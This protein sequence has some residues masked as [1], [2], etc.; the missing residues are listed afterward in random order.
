MSLSPILGSGWIVAIHTFAAVAALFVGAVQLTRSKGTASHRKL[1]YV[2]IALMAVAAATSF[3]I[4]EIRQWG[5]FSWIHLLSIAIVYGLI[6]G[7][8]QARRG[9]I[10]E[11]RKTM[12]L[13]YF[14]G[15]I[16]AG[17]FTLTP[18]RAVHEAL[19]GG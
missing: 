11:H 17:A 7:I 18:G 4:H 6:G 1:G 16:V 5:L 8:R 13:L 2:W 12:V 15:L 3:F 19:F 9:D 14:G 10:A